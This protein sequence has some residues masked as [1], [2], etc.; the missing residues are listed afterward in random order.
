MDLKQLQYFVVSV[1]NG[2]FKK[3]A[4]IL[5]TSQPHISKTIKT[6]EAELQLELLRR[7]SRGIEV[8][9]A[10]R[11]VY[12]YACRVLVEAGKIQNVQEG[13]DV[14]A[15]CI[16][17]NSND[18]LA[19]LFERFYAEELKLGM[20]VQYTECSME[21]IFQMVHRHTAEIGFV[22]VDKKQMTAFRQMLKHRHLEF[23]ELGRMGPLLFV[24]P[25]SPLYRAS[26]VTM[27]ELR[28]LQYIQMQDEQDT[29]SIQFLQ[30]NE[31]YQYHRR[32]NQVILT[33]SRQMVAQIV[34]ETELCSISCG[35][36]PKRIGYDS[37]R[38]ITIR[39]TEKSITLGYVK[40]Q[41][42]DLCQEITRF[43]EYVKTYIDAKMD[44]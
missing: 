41:R 7:K 24:G 15:L 3:A 37:L 28:K 31:D 19:Y 30:G 8:T 43:T 12:E 13:G 1:D 35:M 16:A 44:N 14:R 18:E 4:E 39:G 26:F 9:Q 40:R 17:A 34:S 29:L 21:E 33:S 2:S 27:K 36:H 38:G 5:Y 32:R 25:Q 6:L 23:T 10:G 20:H 22:Y 42:D 11:K